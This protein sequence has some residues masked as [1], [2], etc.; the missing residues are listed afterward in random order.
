MPDTETRR[1]FRRYAVQWNAAVVFE[2]DEKKPVLLTRTEDL[3]AGGAALRSSYE[4]L[5]GSMVTLL[6]DRSGIGDNTLPKLLRI[7]ARVVSTDRVGG[8]EQ[9]RHGLG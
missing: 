2:G 6:L 8:K 4:D 7:R 9:Y 1:K 5:T 3:S